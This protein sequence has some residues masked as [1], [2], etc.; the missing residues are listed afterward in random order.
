MCIRDSIQA[1]QKDLNVINREQD[2]MDGRPPIE[3][4]QA[5]NPIVIIDEPQSVDNTARAKEAIKTLNPLLCLRYSATHVNPYNLLYRLDPIR[6]YDMRLVKQIEVSSIRAEDN[7][8]EVY[9]LS[10]IHILSCKNTK[11][12]GY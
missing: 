6:A 1:F 12:K 4:V 10:L 8:N 9:I 2:R 3:Y 7:F 11:R 5:T